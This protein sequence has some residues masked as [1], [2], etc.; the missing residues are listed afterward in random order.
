MRTNVPTWLCT[1]SWLDQSRATLVELFLNFENDSPV[2]H[3]KLFQDLIEA[4]CALASEVCGAALPAGASALTPA[5]RA[6]AKQKPGPSPTMASRERKYVKPPQSKEAAEVRARA[7]ATLS[8]CL[9]H[10]VDLSG[11]VRTNKTS[12]AGWNDEGEGK[13]DERR[14]EERRRRVRARRLGLRAR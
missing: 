5:T 4:L 13:V 1:L 3:W 8:T 14:D 6:Q 9:R 10:L 7:L 12:A 11:T 2:P